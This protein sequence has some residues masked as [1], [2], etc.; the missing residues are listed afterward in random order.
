MTP[1]VDVFGQLSIF[2]AVFFLILGV[3]NLLPELFVGY[4]ERYQT[5]TRRTA[6]E[7]NKFFIHIKPTQI[8]GIA[9]VLG[10]LMG[11][12]TGSWVLAAAIIAAGLVAPRIL[13]SLWKEIR[14]SQFEAQLMDGLLLI[15]NSLRSGLDII[16]GIERVAAGMKPPISEE[17]GLVL[18]AYRL[19]TP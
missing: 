15:A 5:S 2:L 3:V 9:G 4:Q 6:R 8:L 10:A 12:A 18:N 14:S 11:I 7:L 19:G 16:A 17:F 1:S 13:L